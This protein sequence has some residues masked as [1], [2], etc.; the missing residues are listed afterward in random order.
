[1][2]RDVAT[3]SSEVATDV[4]SPGSVLLSR[5]FQ[6]IVLAIATKAGLVLRDVDLRASLRLAIDSQTDA[7]NAGRA[8]T[9]NELL[10]IFSARLSELAHPQ[11]VAVADCIHTLEPALALIPAL[12]GFRDLLSRVWSLDTVHPETATEPAWMPGTPRGQCGVS[13]AWLAAVLHRDYSIPS[14]FCQGSL[15]FNDQRAA[16]ILDHCWLEINGGAG[17]ELILDLTCGQARGFER[18]IVIDSKSHLDRERVHYVSH[19]RLSTSDLPN[20]PVWPRYQTLLRN[21]GWP[22]RGTAQSSH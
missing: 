2:K 3:S 16:D 7:D 13:S 6:G 10:A 17:E 22:P 18:Q 12:R 4:T 14:T 19:E 20:N 1:M 9:V 15:I 21:L 8:S 11:A 5:D